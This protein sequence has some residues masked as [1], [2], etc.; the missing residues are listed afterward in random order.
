MAELVPPVPGMRANIA[1]RVNQTIREMHLDGRE[2]RITAVTD[3]Y[4][5]CVGIASGRK[6]RIKRENLKNYVIVSLNG[7]A[8]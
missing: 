8:Q 5:D 4:V 2:R 1:P 6:T 3:D 7:A